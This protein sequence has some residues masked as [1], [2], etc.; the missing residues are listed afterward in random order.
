MSSRS[1]RLTRFLTTAEPTARLTTNPT[2]GGSPER[3]GS[4]SRWPTM[5]GLPAREPPRTAE[6]KSALRRIR[7]CAG[8]IR[9]SA[10]RG[11]CACGPP[12]RHARPGCACAAGSRA[13]SRGADCSAGTCAYSLEL[14]GYFLTVGS[15]PGTRVTTCG[16]RI[17][18]RLP[19]G[20][21][22][23]AGRPPLPGLRLWKAIL[24]KLPRSPCAAGMPRAQ[25][26]DS[27]VDRERLLAAWYAR[28]AHR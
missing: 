19:S 15:V 21:L 28:G 27:S 6:V 9:H 14:P 26:V 17:H 11:P 22:P 8:R 3:A 2:L 12:G 25:H 23:F 7:N 4:T 16:S 13:S 20:T 18:P 1:R 10:S 24:P 5:V